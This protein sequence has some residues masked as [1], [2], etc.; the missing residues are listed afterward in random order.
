MNYRN[1]QECAAALIGKYHK[2]K[3][4]AEIAAEVRAIMQSNTSAISISAYRGMI[5]K[6][7]LAP[8]TEAAPAGA[9]PVAAVPVVN[10]S[11]WA[12]AAEWKAA[13]IE[14]ERTGS[15][16]KL[17]RTRIGY[18][19][20]YDLESPDR[21]IAVKA[22]ARAR[23]NQGVLRLELTPRET[24]VLLKDPLYYVY[25]C[26][27]DAAAGGKM[28]MLDRTSLLSVMQL[29]LTARLSIPVEAGLAMP[30]T[31]KEPEMAPPAEKDSEVA[32]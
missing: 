20:G 9:N 27:G 26:L 11:P 13:G 12:S 10:Y 2:T 4:N 5:R 1:V 14:Q 15:T 21:H 16:P 8:Q 31:E 23:R 17:M 19:A 29:N 22:V 3:S 28:I 32:S 7:K 24:E 25:L 6:G 30:E 18:P